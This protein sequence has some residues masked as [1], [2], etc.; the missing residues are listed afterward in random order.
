MLYAQMVKEDREDKLMGYEVFRF[1][2]AEFLHSNERDFQEIKE[3]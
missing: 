1:G 2:G 3:I